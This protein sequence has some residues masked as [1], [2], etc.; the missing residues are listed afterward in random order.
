MANVPS[1]TPVLVIGGGPAGSTV[2]TLLAREGFE[3]TL[4]EREVFPRYHI[5]ESLLPSA[6]P[7]F[8]MLGVRQKVEK[9]GFTLKRGAYYDWGHDIW[10]LDFGEL[11]ENRTHA[12]QVVRAEFD[13]ILLDHSKEQG[14]KVFEGI[15]VDELEFEDGRPVRARWSDRAATNGGGSGTI[16]FD[17]LIDGSGRS[18]V[19]SNRIH[20]DRRFHEVF[21][22]V[23]IWSYW[24]GANRLEGDKAG[25]AT[26]AS[27][28]EGWLWAIPL[29]D[30][31]MSVGLVMHKSALQDR[32]VEALDSHYLKAIA[33]SEIV[34]GFLAPATRIS[35]VQ[36]ESDYSY[37]AETFCG[38]GYFIIGDAA[39]FL[40]PL[41][42]TGVHLAM[43]SG[44]LAAA[45]TAT[46]LRRDQTEE[47]VVN[48][49]EATYR[50]AYLRFLVFVSI[51]Y[52][53]YKGK[54]SYF[55][56]AQRLT[57]QEYSGEEMRKAFLNLISGVEDMDDLVKDGHVFHER[58]L[59]EMCDRIEENLNIRRDK[60]VLASIKTQ[61]PT[62]IKRNNQFFDAVEGF[63]PMQPEE[64]VEGLYITTEPK[65][66]LSAVRG[67]F[68]VQ[69][70]V[71][72]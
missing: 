64:A 54:G 5:G 61:D 65:L 10:S 43:F 21:K 1:H 32:S 67:Y 41:L 8:D 26:V 72:R 25:Y 9:H 60:Q 55:W 35:G 46:L 49:F 45:S 70:E 58:I 69:A 29:H 6:L 52:Q 57:R 63:F 2:S 12:F 16:S 4:L 50:K 36:V 37:A 13:K 20:H 27:V 19:I 39:C 68:P 48:F 23:A 53:Q 56:E 33:E 44:L 47:Q 66:G 30:D 28:Q 59:G 24:K 38:P 3:V 11:T 31:R 22:N 40:D 18:G 17:V 15:N 14:V 7:I 34:G 62:R 42:S 71:A 51:F